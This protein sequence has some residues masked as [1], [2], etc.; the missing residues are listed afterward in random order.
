[1]KPITKTL[2]IFAVIAIILIIVM[3]PALSGKNKTTDKNKPGTN[4]K[5][6]PGGNGSGTGTNNNT[7]TTNQAVSASLFQSLPK[8][9][10]P[11]AKGQKSQLV[12]ILQYVINKR[13]SFKLDLDGDF[14]PLTEEAVKACFFGSPTV[15]E[16][17]LSANC[18]V[19]TSDPEI[20]VDE[21][22]KNYFTYFNLI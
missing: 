21:Y 20:V 3:W 10:Y 6:N 19:I 8:G 13:F 18:K 7:S 2:L 11:L 17:L 16:L 15:S 5:T 1:M 4:P 14:G 12:Y 9:T 22:I